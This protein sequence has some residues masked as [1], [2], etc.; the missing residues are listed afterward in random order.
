MQPTP[1]PRHGAGWWGVGLTTCP[2]SCWHSRLPSAV[3]A[4]GAPS[5]GCPLLSPVECRLQSNTAREL[6]AREATHRED[7][8]AEPWWGWHRPGT[9]RVFQLYL[10][11]STVTGVGRANVPPKGVWTSGEGPPRGLWNTPSSKDHG[12]PHQVREPALEPT[13]PGVPIGGIEAAADGQT[14][15]EQSCPGYTEGTQQKHVSHVQ[16]EAG[17]AVPESRKPLESRVGAQPPASCSP[18]PGTACGSWPAPPGL[19]LILRSEILLT[20]RAPTPLADNH[21]PSPAPSL[22]E[23]LNSAP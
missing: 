1:Q 12:K 6:R 20:C 7:R 2:R 14:S 17:P 5:P 22:N 15:G 13:V 21:F 4:A 11:V 8:G 23:P 16:P 3:P 19:L 18:A 9:F 10:T